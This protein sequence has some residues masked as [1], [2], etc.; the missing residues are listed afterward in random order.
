MK[1]ILVTGNIGS[2]KTTLCKKLSSML[3]ISAYHFDQVAWQANWKR[4]TPEQREAKTR[5]LMEKTEWVI[6]GVSKELMERADTI[7]FLDFPRVVCAWRT[8]KRNILCRFG[9][10]PEMPANCPDYKH[11]SFIIRI[12]WCFPRKQN[13]WILEAMEKMKHQKNVVHIRTNEELS[14]FMNQGINRLL[15]RYQENA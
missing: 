6:D 12:I 11:L 10:R 8:L 7:I 14:V 3:G 15:N 13:P 5:Q 9:T 1:R 2:G 4:P